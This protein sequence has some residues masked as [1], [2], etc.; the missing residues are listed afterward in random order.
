[1]RYRD[2]EPEAASFTLLLLPCQFVFRFSSS[3]R[4]EAPGSQ[5]TVRCSQLQPMHVNEN[6]ERNLNA[7]RAQRTQKSERQIVNLEP[8][9]NTN[10]EVRTQK[11]ER[12]V[13]QYTG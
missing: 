12:L 5:I 6:R 4:F 10:R 11:R 7:N 1:M 2:T 9:M 3:S 8:N 13:S